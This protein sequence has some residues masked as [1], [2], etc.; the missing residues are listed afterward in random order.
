VGNLAIRSFE[1]TRLTVGPDQLFAESMFSDAFNVEE[2]GTVLGR[3][4][5][6]WLAAGEP[7]EN[8]FLLPSVAHFKPRRITSR[9]EGRMVLAV[10]LDGDG[11][12]VAGEVGDEVIFGMRHPFGGFTLA[13]LRDCSQR[14]EPLYF[15]ISLQ[16]DSVD[17]DFARLLLPSVDDCDRISRI[18][19]AH[20]FIGE[21][22]RG[23]KSGV[24]L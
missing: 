4:Y 24:A 19:V 14:R 9:A 17:F 12:P 10:E 15:R 18:D 20:R 5:D 22:M 2:R 13:S 21:R 11:L 23:S 7:T 6:H 8:S 16:L 1:T 3:I